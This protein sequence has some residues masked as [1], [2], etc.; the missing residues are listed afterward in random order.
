[1]SLGDALIHELARTTSP[2]TVTAERDGRTAE[3]DVTDV[4]RLGVRIREVRVRTGQMTDVVEAAGRLSRQ[5][6]SLPE[7]LTPVE[8]DRRLGAATL[9]TDPD[10]MRDHEFFTLDLDA[11]GNHRLRRER[12][13]PG[14]DRVPTDWTT[15]HRQLGRCVDELGDEIGR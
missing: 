7:R 11:D 5:V 9:R 10:E 4:D 8:A 12:A 14:A 1:M 3:V 2:G 6:R 15:T 13:M